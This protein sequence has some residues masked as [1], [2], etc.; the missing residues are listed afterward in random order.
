MLSVS[1]ETCTVYDFEQKEYKMWDMKCPRSYIKLDTNMYTVLWT[2][3]GGTLI[4][5]ARR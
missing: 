4:E 5:G 1:T 2:G 3:F